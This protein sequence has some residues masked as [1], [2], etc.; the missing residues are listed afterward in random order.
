MSV[1]LPGLTDQKCNPPCVCLPVD[2][3]VDKSDNNEDAEAENDTENEVEEK[4]H[5]AGVQ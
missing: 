2:D 5:H 3:V 1:L 4:D